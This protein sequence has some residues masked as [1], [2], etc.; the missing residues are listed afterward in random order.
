MWG[1]L[2]RASLLKPL[3]LINYYQE[4]EP[5]LTLING[6]RIFPALFWNDLNR[7]RKKD[8]ARKKSPNE[9]SSNEKSA[10]DKVRAEQPE[11]Y[12]AAKTAIDSGLLRGYIEQSPKWR[13]YKTKV[14]FSSYKR[15]NDSK[16]FHSRTFLLELFGRAPKKYFSDLLLLFFFLR[17]LLHFLLQRRSEDF[18]ND[19]SPAHFCSIWSWDDH[20]ALAARLAGV[21]DSPATS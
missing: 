3:G 10:N 9:K 1:R 8:G 19:V 21:R 13:L 4:Q 20:C 18:L 6:K 11:S 16:T 17:N 2:I 12:F 7:G 15:L 5:M 14:G